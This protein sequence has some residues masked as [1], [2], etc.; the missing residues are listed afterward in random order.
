MWSVELFTVK[1]RVGPCRVDRTNN[2]LRFE[3]MP[4]PLFRAKQIKV[5][6]SK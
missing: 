5:K 3:Y 1:V 4:L 6:G 2:E